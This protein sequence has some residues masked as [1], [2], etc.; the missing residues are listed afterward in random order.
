MP[1]PGRQILQLKRTAGVLR[2]NI[3][4][5]GL[6][7]M[8]YPVACHFFNNT[9]WRGYTESPP[10]PH[11][12]ENRSPRHARQ[13]KSNIVLRYCWLL[14]PGRGDYH[15]YHVHY[16]VVDWSFLSIITLRDPGP[17]SKI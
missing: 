11:N 6:D 16:R 17:M 13:S 8:N 10:L 3:D 5:L 14:R 1:Q 9:P 15:D 2:E 12:E 4:A 7:A